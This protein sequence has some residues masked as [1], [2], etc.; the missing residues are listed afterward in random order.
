[1]PK[2]L[3]IVIVNWNSGGF[4]KDCLNS[5]KAAKS[6]LFDLSRIIVVDNASHDGS[7][8]GL[9]GIDSSLIVIKNS[10]NRGF[11]AA[12][13]QGARGSRADYLLFLNPDVR[14][15][16]N[17]LSKPVEFLERADNEQVGIVGIQ[18]LDDEGRVG[19]TCARFPTPLM[20][21]TYIL[22]LDRV[23]P[24]RFSSHFMREWPHDKTRA[25]DHLI[26]AFYFVRRFIFEEINGFDETFFVYL[27][28]LD[29]SLR[30]RQA[31]FYSQ[32]LAGVHAY[33]KGGGTSDQIKARRLFY[34]RRSHI[35]YAFKHFTKPAAAAVTLSMLLV[36]PWLRLGVAVKAGSSEQ[37]TD[38][39]NAYLLLW[40]WLPELMFHK[41]KVL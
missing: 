14:L 40:G 28:D 36:E 7:A 35:L 27:E 3:D 34:S 22:G 19:R 31:G 5:V 8:D 26:G 33:H 6:D 25:V 9:E 41:R 11:A 32:Y 2:S 18:L 38:T 13:N 16:P 30:T 1:M 15:F 29:F 24:E 37:V 23:F 12:C 17:S 20:F 4:L 21:L 39:L 10:E